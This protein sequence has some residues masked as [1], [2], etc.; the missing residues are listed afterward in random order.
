M[1]ERDN[2]ELN[3]LSTELIERID[4]LSVFVENNVEETYL[5]EIITDSLYEIKNIVKLYKNNLIKPKLM[6]KKLKPWL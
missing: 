5:E 6:G 1:N 3:E 4:S 2:D